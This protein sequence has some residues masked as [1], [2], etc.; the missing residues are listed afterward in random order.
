MPSPRGDRR[1]SSEPLLSR[2]RLVRVGR[3][4]AVR[5]CNLWPGQARADRILTWTAGCLAAVVAL[6][7]LGLALVDW[8]LA[9]GPIGGFASARLHRTVV[10]DGPLR[11]HLWSLKPWATAE[12][13]RIGDPAWA[14]PDQTATVQRLTVQIELLSLLRG[15][16]VL[17]RLEADQ[18]VIRLRRDALGRATWDFSGGV[19][20][21]RPFRMP[22]IRHFQI[23]DG[24]L[25][26]VD[27][28]RHL[29]FDG[30]ISAAERPGEPN[31]RFEMAGDG[32][33]NGEP[34][35]L[36]LTGGPLLN[37][38]A[39]HP[40]PFEAHVRAGATQVDALGVVPKP[41]DMA[42]FSLDLSAQ[43]PDLADL[44][45]LTR[46]ALPNTP[47][48]RLTGHLERR[49]RLYAITG[50]AGRVGDSDLAGQLSVETGRARPLLKADLVS[51][52]LDFD[53]LATL[54]GGAPAR[55]RGETVSA[56][57]A[58]VGRRM[59]AE[60]RLLP[61]TTLNV[62]K[63]RSLDA[64]VT[65]R[66]DSI[67]APNLPLRSGAVRIGLDR[68]LL[69]VDPLS[70]Q[71]AQGRV[72]GS[73]Q[74]DARGAVPVTTVDLRLTGARLEQ[75]IP[76]QGRPLTGAVLSRV[77]LSG[78]GD[79]VHRAAAHAH[80]EILVVSPGG[81]IREAFAELLGVNVTR[82]LGLLW[83]KDQGVVPIRCAVA[84]FR[85]VNGQLSANQIVFDTGPVLATGSG[86]IDLDRERIDFRIQGRSK[87]PRLV[88][89]LA[90]IT[91]RGS[92]L[93]PKIGVET[94]KVVAQGGISV[95]LAAV[96]TPLAAVLPFLDPGL[97]KDAACGALI[98]EAQG[99]GAPVR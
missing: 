88:R 12:N 85:A 40:Y 29:R 68:G 24:R 5:L 18:P 47:P 63:I 73:A 84:D 94:G 81:E 17:L 79:S 76:I 31:R 53:D 36:A 97:A 22:P 38:S 91:V 11:V 96:A 99:R 74:L 39:D 98:A 62:E 23:S 3:S 10:L 54:F 7:L 83:S 51:R 28:A 20:P 57:Q 16:I 55:G 50:L 66:A 42:R 58:A 27:A 72:A 69:N 59:A 52:S 95:L 32:R 1:L 61:D 82:G 6:A 8:N 75:L 37:V 64:E 49:D 89:A 46:V 77:R 21:K 2:A 67:H 80:G 86:R 30:A 33:L 87:Q 15:Q 71:L 65:F 45:D 44:Y 41:F 19:A 13:I 43:G 70:L 78:E 4:A 93:S 34:F 14:G 56:A 9:R 25:Q 48:Y 60:R 92:I 90:P 26:I 35:H